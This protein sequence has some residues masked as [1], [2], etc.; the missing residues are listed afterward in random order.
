MNVLLVEDDP[1]LRR[2]LSYHLG[3]AGHNVL[4]AGDGASAL[5]MLD[6]EAVEMIL[7]DVR[8]PGMDGVEL[9]K[10]VRERDPG[11]PVVVMTAYGTISDAVDAMKLGASD[12]LTKPVEKQTLLLAVEKASRIGKLAR[13]NALLRESIRE[14]KPLD[15]I[16]GTSPSLQ[17]MLA[18]LRRVSPTEATVLITGESGTG[19]EL[20]AL[21]IHSLSPRAQGPFVA[22]NCAAVPRDLLESELFGH[23]KGAFTGATEARPGKFQQAHGGT[24]FLDEVGDMHLNLQAKILRALQEKVVDPVGARSPKTVDVRLV[25]A[26]HRDLALGVKEGA[27][28]EDLF[29]RLNVIPIHVP[30]LRDRREDIALLLK[31]FY[32]AYGGGDLK[33]SSSAERLLGS[34]AWPGNVRELQNLCQRLA[35]LHPAQEVTPELLPPDLQGGKEVPEEAAQGLWGLERQAIVKAL[36]EHKGNRSAAARALRIPRHILLYRMKKF[37]IEDH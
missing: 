25:A 13:E 4:S 21:A 33:L 36:D 26:T 30:A 35:V 37:G 7:T 14:K 15:T 8:M 34:Y 10:A 16:L 5:R 6:S 31:H 1:N 20:A 12:Y 27:F 29:W 3:R 11:L 24:L 18:Q 17:E 28:R 23:E 19:K 22:V 32:R 9:L 2:V